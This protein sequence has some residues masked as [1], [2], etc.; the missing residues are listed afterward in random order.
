MEPCDAENLRHDTPGRMF[1]WD[2]MRLRGVTFENWLRGHGHK[3]ASERWLRELYPW[4]VLAR[5]DYHERALG[6]VQ[7]ITH[8][9]VSFGVTLLSVDW[10]PNHGT[11][12][13]RV[14]VDS[15]G[16]GWHARAY[17]DEFDV[18]ASQEGDFVTLFHTARKEPLE[19]FARAFF[20][21]RWEKLDPSVFRSLAASRF[22]AASLV[23]VIAEE[24]FSDCNLEHYPLARVAGGGA[25]M[26]ADGE[27]LWVAHRFYSENAYEWAR[28]HADRAERVVVV[29]FA[30]TKYQFRTDHPG[31]TEVVSALDL[32]SR[33]GGQ[34]TD[35][36]LALMRKLEP[37]RVAVPLQRLSAA[38][39][40]EGELPTTPLTEGDVH[41]A[42]AALRL[43]CQSVPDL[44]Y[45][46]AA[47]VLLN[48]WIE[49]ERRLGYPQRKKFYAFKQRIGELADWVERSRPSGVELWA[50]QLREDRGPVLYF[51]IEGVDLSFHAIPG[52]QRFVSSN[53]EAYTWNGVR[54]KPIASHVLAWAR[55]LRSGLDAHSTVDV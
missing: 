23:A 24:A 37:P 30:D 43:P 9:G 40:G 29:Y 13:Y 27:K 17:A 12:R 18:C 53:G 46:L 1:L 45:Q 54:L 10:Q 31:S 34:N 4:P 41:E 28:R 8:D 16:L 20:H 55:A 42:L 6:V 51:R 11:Y 49:N 21:R 7:K 50:E 5:V 22:L 35:L 52:A 26:F 44:R 47:G 14:R 39:H 25:P 19:K 32:D 48:A 38:L 2:A 33:A 36:V 3:R 15:D